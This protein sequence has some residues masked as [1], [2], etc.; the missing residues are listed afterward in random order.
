M[1]QYFSPPELDL[2]TLTPLSS[3]L[4]VYKNTCAFGIY[5]ESGL[6]DLV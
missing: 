6:D 1:N 4:T 5:V 2:S 3:G